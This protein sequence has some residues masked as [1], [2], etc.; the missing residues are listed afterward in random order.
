MNGTYIFEMVN[1]TIV[2]SATEELAIVNDNDSRYITFKIPSVIDGIDITDKILTVRYVNSLNRYDQF[3]C[4]SREVIT[5]GNEQFVLFDWVLDSNVTSSKGTV[6]YDVSIY[7]TND[8][9]NVSQYILHTKP[10]TFQVEEGL[11][12]TGAPIEDENALQAAIDSFN[13]IAAKYYNDTLAASKAAQA[14]ADAAAKSAASLKVDTTLTL[15]GYAADAKAV[16]DRLT[17]KAES[18][19][20]TSIRSDLQNEIDRA[21]DAESQLKEDLEISKIFK[22]SNILSASDYNFKKNYYYSPSVN[23]FVSRNGNIAYNQPISAG[24]SEVYVSNASIAVFLDKDNR[25]ISHNESSTT[26]ESFAVYTT[27]AECKSIMISW[28]YTADVNK[29]YF[30]K[31]D[32]GSFYTKRNALTKSLFQ[33]IDASQATVDGA[34]LTDAVRGKILE[35]NTSANK[36]YD[37]YIKQGVDFIIKIKPENASVTILKITKD[38]SQ[39]YINHNQ[40]ISNNG[41]YR[42]TASTD[43]LGLRFTD[44]TEEIKFSVYLSNDDNKALEL[45][46]PEQFRPDKNIKERNTVSGYRI[47]ALERKI[48]TAATGNIT[49]YDVSGC[50]YIRISP[51]RFYGTHGYAFFYNN[52]F[53]PNITTHIEQ[54]KIIDSK[55]TLS[56]QDTVIKVPDGCN[57][58]GMTWLNENNYVPKV[59]KMLFAEKE[60]SNLQDFYGIFKNFGNQN[61]YS[62]LSLIANSTKSTNLTSQTLKKLTKND[63]SFG[64]MGQLV[65]KDGMCYAS[66]LQNSGTDG[67]ATYSKTSELVLVKFLLTDALSDSFSP[68]TN[69]QVKVIGKLGSACAGQIAK[70]IF[71]DNAMCLIDNKLYITFMFISE[72]D[73]DAHLFRKV[74]NISSDIFEDEVVCEIEYKG[75]T[76]PFT[77]STINM[78]YGENHLNQNASGIME[79]VSEWSKYNSEYYATGIN[80]DKPNNGFIIKT[81]DFKKYY[82][83]DVLPFNDNGIAEIASIV[84]DNK[85]YVACRQNYGLPYLLLAFYNLR[86]GTWGTPYRI[87][88]GNARPWFYKKDGALYLINTIEEYYRRYINISNVLTSGYLGASAPIKTTATLYNCGSYIAT[89]EYNDNTYYVCTYNG[90]I[91]F[92]ILDVIKYDETIVNNKFLKLLE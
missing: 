5:E 25:V 67:E 52:G 61:C 3:F 86:N 36:T 30:A 64:H 10:A 81:S 21:T 80:G 82:F 72:T 46:F 84:Y 83:V 50:E 4:N 77:N 90:T 57:Y 39:N 19:E 33:N 38:G 91:Y 74:Y 79:I 9:T 31:Y 43:I 15:S 58:F 76:Y 29:L 40:H 55:E 1:R 35:S 59:T 41:L 49:F 28:Y 24:E 47:N 62:L 87:Q 73:S 66:F 89:S 48:D 53:V 56:F 78:I 75:K 26:V 85:L 23:D 34:R 68:D 71:K 45:F 37:L 88:D 22:T 27:P 16:G 32:S 92:G 11:L 18:S 60:N 69:T 65:I 63:I 70:S 54:V 13:A 2:P 8:M 51:F 44:M 12:D 7:D 17:G 6:T 42:F 20:V 14:S